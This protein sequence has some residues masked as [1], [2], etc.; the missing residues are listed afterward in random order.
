MGKNNWGIGKW[1]YSEHA[2]VLYMEMSYFSECGN[3]IFNQSSKIFILLVNKFCHSQK[4]TCKK[5]IIG[6]R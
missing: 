4:S 5:W 3:F 2:T 1:D 6:F